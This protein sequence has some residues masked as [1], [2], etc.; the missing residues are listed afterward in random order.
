[1]PTCRAGAA[2]QSTGIT[3]ARHN[4]E[5]GIMT[6]FMEGEPIDRFEIGPWRRHLH[7]IVRCVVV[8]VCTADAEIRAGCGT[9]SLGPWLNLT[10]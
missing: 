9:Q 10:R 5:G 7:E 1:M 2:H 4:P 6:E 8:G 3:S